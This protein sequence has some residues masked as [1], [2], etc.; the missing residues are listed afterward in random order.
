[1][2]YVY[3]IKQCNGDYYQGET[4]DLK[5]RIE[6]HQKGWNK[7]TSRYLPIRLICYLAFVDRAK[8]REFERYLKTGSGYA[9][10]NKHLV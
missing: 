1:M 6:E 8:A 10:R 3:L 2:H 4:V 7:S 5:R 9:F